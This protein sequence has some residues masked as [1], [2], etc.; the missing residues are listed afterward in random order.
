M[1]ISALFKGISLSV[2][3]FDIFGFQLMSCLAHNSCGLLTE[4]VPAIGHF[5]VIKCVLDSTQSVRP[6]YIYS[7]KMQQNV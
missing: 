3:F 6:E 1:L 4:R 5:C 7:V 2:S